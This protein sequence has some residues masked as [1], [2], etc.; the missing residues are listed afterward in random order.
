MNERCQR[1]NWPD[2]HRAHKQPFGKRFNEESGSANGGRITF[3]SHAF[4]APPLP[5]TEKPAE[6][7]T[8]VLHST[9]ERCVMGAPK[10]DCGGGMRRLTHLYC[11]GCGQHKCAECQR[12]VDAN[13]YCDP[14]ARKAVASPP[15]QAQPKENQMICGVQ[16]GCFGTCPN[17]LPCP[18]HPAKDAALSLLQMARQ[19]LERLPASDQQT[20]V[21]VMLADLNARL[22]PQAQ[23]EET[24]TVHA[25]WCDKV[26]PCGC[27]G[28]Q[29][30]GEP[31]RRGGRTFE[32]WIKVFHG[33]AA[34]SDEME[35][36]L[37]AL[38]AAAFGERA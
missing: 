12:D 9:P 17:L 27:A 7:R 26:S 4:I 37:V 14:C 3:T 15:P 34:I 5:S 18:E 13:G 23:P 38:A 32:E 16:N 19:E 11:D 28:R 31:K 1:C 25:E 24:P 20:K 29:P 6:A 33:W 22:T 10:C 30:E 21:A 8:G 35:E 36:Q 2:F